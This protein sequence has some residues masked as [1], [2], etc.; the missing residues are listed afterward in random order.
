[1]GDALRVDPHIEALRQ[2]VTPDSVVLDLGCGPGLF[3][4]VACKFG[5]RRVYG[6]EPD[7]AINIGREAAAANG[8][9]D[10]IDFF[11]DLSTRVALPEPATIIIFDLRGVMPWFTQNIPT[12]IDARQRLLAPGGVW[13]PRRDLAWATIVDDEQQYKQIVGPW[14]PGKY[15][16]LSAGRSR[17]TNCWRKTRSKADSFLAE[18]VCWATLD[19]REVTSPDVHADISW[20]A[21]RSG[22][23]HGIAVWFDAELIDG[24]GFTNHPAAPELVYSN[25][26]L[27]FSQPVNV[28]EGETISVRLS[29]DHVQNDY[30]WSWTTEFKDQR[31]RFE[32]ST[33]YGVALSAEQLRQKYEQRS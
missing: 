22:V 33:F 8:F 14:E 12:I 1:M 16:D 31:I 20:R 32:Q 2:T 15:V 30:V 6:I 24:I 9:A 21:T 25:G 13:I 11:Q 4:L 28:R 10:R 18:P 27:P 3:A 23:A 17:I 29:A 7:N 19:Y 5:A 26:F